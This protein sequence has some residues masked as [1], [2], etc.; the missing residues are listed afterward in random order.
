MIASLRNWLQSN[1][2]TVRTWYQ[3]ETVPS[4]ASLPFGVI[5]I[6]TDQ[7]VVNNA[8]GMVREVRLTVYMPQGSWV[9]VDDAVE[10]IRTKLHGQVLT[11]VSGG[12]RFRL[13]WAQ[14][15]T[16]WP[17]PVRKAFARTVIFQV[18]LKI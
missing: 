6:G 12:E 1:L 13:E 8:R 16:G 4:T 10:E 17:D 3:I 14:T 2:T 18:P 15:T 11:R 9:A 5:E 7:R